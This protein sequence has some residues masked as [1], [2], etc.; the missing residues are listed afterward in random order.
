MEQCWLARFQT[1]KHA[2]HVEHVGRRIGGEDD[3]AI[4]GLFLVQREGDEPN[5]V[6]T[7]QGDDGLAGHRLD[8]RRHYL[9][10]EFE[11]VLGTWFEDADDIG[12]APFAAKAAAS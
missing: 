11:Y 12:C 6:D 3:N 2:V 1:V 9:R 8:L 4:I 7:A 10:F 5:A